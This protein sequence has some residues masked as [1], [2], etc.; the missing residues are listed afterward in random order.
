MSKYKKIAEELLDD[1]FS[2][3]GFD[4]DLDQE[5]IEEIVDTWAKIIKENV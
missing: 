2:R 3:S 1:L 4:L 5:T